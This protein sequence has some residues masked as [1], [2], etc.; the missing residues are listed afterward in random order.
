MEAKAG[1][2]HIKFALPAYSATL[3]VFEKKD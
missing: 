3:Y 1:K 2:L